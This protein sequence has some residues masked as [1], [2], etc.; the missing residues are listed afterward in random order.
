MNVFF[1]KENAHTGW[2]IQARD[3]GKVLAHGRTIDEA[4]THLHLH[5]GGRVTIKLEGRIEGI[6]ENG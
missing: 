1:V 5:C 2:K 6:K 4:I 3:G